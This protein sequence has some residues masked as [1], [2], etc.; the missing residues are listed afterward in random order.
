MRRKDT[1]G[2]GAED[3][4]VPACHVSPL[5]PP[6]LGLQAGEAGAEPARRGEPPAASTAG[7]P[8]SG[9]LPLQRVSVPR[10]RPARPTPHPRPQAKS[11]T[12]SSS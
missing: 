11:L 2:K 12:Q 1:A 9:R 10:L 6:F 5:L 7:S 4:L 8:L 3:R